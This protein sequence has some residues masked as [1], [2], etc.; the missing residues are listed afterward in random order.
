M[1]YADRLF[2]YFTECKLIK[3]FIQKFFIVISV[4][5]IYGWSN[6][7]SRLSP[8]LNCFLFLENNI[9]VGEQ[10]VKQNTIGAASD[11]VKWA[12]QINSPMKSL[13]KICRDFILKAMNNVPSSLQQK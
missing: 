13:V 10:K 1:V 12:K 5:D 6:A 2:D 4:A 3:R 8:Y 9:C 11:L 7:E